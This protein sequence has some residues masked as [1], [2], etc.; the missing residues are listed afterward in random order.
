MKQI[1]RLGLVLLLAAAAMIPVSSEAAPILA[2]TIDRCFAEADCSQYT[3]P[4]GQIALP[5]CN[6]QSCTTY[7][8][9]RS[10]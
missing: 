7:C 6:A 8:V 4:S 1:F 9:C 10:F 5:R 3:C 2:C